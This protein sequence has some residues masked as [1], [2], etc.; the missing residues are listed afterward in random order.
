MTKDPK[1]D[2]GG[3]YVYLSIKQVK[4]SASLRLKQTPSLGQNSVPLELQNVSFSKVAFTD[5]RVFSSTY[6]LLSTLRLFF[7]FTLNQSG[8]QR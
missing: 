2:P 3:S 6:G 7:K 8:A 4:S 5:L 1:E